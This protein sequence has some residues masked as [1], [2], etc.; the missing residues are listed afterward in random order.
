MRKLKVTLQVVL[1][2]GTTLKTVASS[3]ASRT[4]RRRPPGAGAARTLR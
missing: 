3:A 2:D 1:A 4:V